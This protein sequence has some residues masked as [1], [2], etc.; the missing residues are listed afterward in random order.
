MLADFFRRMGEV[1]FDRP[2]A[3]R[4][5]IYEQQ[6]VLRGENVARVRLAVQYLLGAAAFAQHSSQAPQRDHEPITLVDARLHSR[7]ESSHRA[8]GFGEPSSKLDFELCDLMR[9]RCHAGQD[10]TRQQAQSELVGVLEN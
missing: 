9:Y 10:V 2:T 7:L 1:E 6:P 5:E 3:A 8:A 4:L